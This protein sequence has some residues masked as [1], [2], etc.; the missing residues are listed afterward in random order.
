MN[1]SSSPL[2]LLY[3]KCYSYFPDTSIDI[4]YKV[5]LDVEYR[6]VWDKYHP[7]H[8]FHNLMASCSVNPTLVENKKEGVGGDL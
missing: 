1:I 6:L 7:N 4:S 2:D 3:Y 5:A 8:V